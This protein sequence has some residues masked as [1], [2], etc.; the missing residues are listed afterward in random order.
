MQLER[1]KSRRFVGYVDPRFD[2]DDLRLLLEDPYDVGK[3]E[4]AERVPTRPGRVVHCITIESQRGPCEVYTHLLTNT[5]LREMLRKPQAFTVL[6]TGRRM[7]KFGLPTSR[8]LAAVRP[9]WSPLNR[10]SFV[11]TLA[12]TDAVPLS[13]LEPDE[14]HGGIGG[15]KKLHLIRQ[16]ATQT[17]WMHAHGFY[18]KDLIAQNI[19]VG[20]RRS[21]PVIWFVGLGRAGIAAFRPPF[22]RE[23]QWASD[24][25]ALM[26]SEVK[27]INERDRVVF[28]ETYLR[29]LGP[30]RGAELVKAI[31]LRRLKATK[32]GNPQ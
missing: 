2:C 17:A 24:L 11:V 15:F 14:F 13:A 29:A 27:A 32:P 31:L 16:I 26:R 6:R 7:L 28:L 21:T 5:K 10:T 19:L 3:F 23:W 12:I 4:G 8:V 9:R 22:L 20:R 30:E 25:L 18:H 1:Y